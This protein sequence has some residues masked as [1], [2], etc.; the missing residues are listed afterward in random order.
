[1]Q[2]YLGS[3]DRLSDIINLRQ[4][5]KQRQR[6]QADA[7]A[8]ANRTRHGMTRLQK[9]RAQKEADR[10]QRLLDGKR[11]GTTDGSDGSAGDAG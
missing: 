10:R 6:K 7:D 5:R 2:A 4:A 8:A 1:V 11:L 9:E 3:G